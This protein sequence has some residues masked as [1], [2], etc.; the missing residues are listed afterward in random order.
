[1]RRGR[2]PGLLAGSRASEAPRPRRRPGAAVG[3]HAFPAR[4]P[5]SFRLASSCVR[6]PLQNG[7][8]AAVEPGSSHTAK[9]TCL[10][11]VA[12]LSAGPTPAPRSLR[13]VSAWR[14]SWG[15][16]VSHLSLSSQRG[17]ALDPTQKAC[18]CRVM[19]WPHGT[20]EIMWVMSQNILESCGVFLQFPSHPTAVYHHPHPSF[21]PRLGPED[22]EGEG[23]S[24]LKAPGS[25]WAHPCTHWRGS[26]R[27]TATLCVKAIPLLR[28]ELSKTCVT[29]QPEPEATDHVFLKS[30][31]FFPL[32]HPEVWKCLALASVLPVNGEHL[33]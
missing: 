29:P 1:M 23:P 17:T 2:R 16:V 11:V 32:R 20:G 25:G 15:W 30:V 22:P 26:G 31:L 33:P 10:S 3:A 18:H 9:D 8:A 13:A 21:S 7:Q 4:K 19:G 27:T 28:E 24:L 6:S 14:G 12:S 5:A